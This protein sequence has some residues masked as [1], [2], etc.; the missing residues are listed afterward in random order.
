MKIMKLLIFNDNNKK[1]LLIITIDTAEGVQACINVDHD[2]L[3][4]FSLL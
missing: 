4:S 1:K 2:A 3:D